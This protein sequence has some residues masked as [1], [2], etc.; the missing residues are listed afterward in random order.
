M[1]ISYAARRLQIVK[2]A[3]TRL[4][5]EQAD[6]AR[7]M[8]GIITNRATATNDAGDRIV[9]ASARV[10]EALEITLWVDVIK[11][12]YMGA[13]EPFGRAGEPQSPYAR[14]IVDGIRSATRNAVDEQVAFLRR[15]ASPIV[16]AHLTGNRPPIRMTEARGVYDPFYQWLDPNGYR[17]SDRVWQTAVESRAAINRFLEYH[18]SAETAAVDIARQLE[19][20]LLPEQRQI[21]TRR[22]YGRVGNYSARRLARTEITAAAGRGTINAAQVNPYVG[23]IRWRLSG[24]HPRIDICDEYANGGPNQNGIYPKNGVPQYPPHPHCLCS[25]LPVM[26]ENPA[27]VGRNFEAEI[28]QVTRRAQTLAGIMNPEWLTSAILNGVIDEVITTL[29][30]SPLFADFA[31]AV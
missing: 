20:F 6:L 18:I 24:S 28:Q 13:N 4:K 31:F 29:R 17:L 1:A 2:E 16:F 27:E 10:R 11:P 14:L 22:P 19:Q 15:V 5:R 23:G 3:G 7:R 21:Q 30:A 25:L 12:Y 8:G 9:P 26:V